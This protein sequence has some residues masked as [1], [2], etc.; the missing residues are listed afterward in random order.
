MIVIGLTGSIGMGKSTVAG[1][2]REAGLPVFDADAVVH[3]LYSRGGE[4]VEPVARRFAGVVLEGSVDRTA[5]AQAVLG[6][7]EALAELEAI[8]HPL[9]RA[10]RA[11]FL[12]CL[13]KQGARAAV[14][15]IPLLFETGG[16]EDVDLVVVVSAPP[17]VQRDRVLARPGMTE[18]KLAAIRA[19]QTPEDEKR[20]DADVVIDTSGS[21]DET[22]TQV[23]RLISSLDSRPQHGHDNSHA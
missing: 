6:K 23:E 17:E 20:A 4:A 2:M 1:M 19:R 11:R 16:D 13:R 18:E 21:L 15:E 14:L 5:L 12:E 22:R 10:R 3:E 7:P 8:V 9:V